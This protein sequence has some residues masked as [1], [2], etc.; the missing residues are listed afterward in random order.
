MPSGRKGKGAVTTSKH[1][2]KGVSTYSSSLVEHSSC[3]PNGIPSFMLPTILP[4]GMG[5][6]SNTKKLFCISNTCI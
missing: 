6:I 5:S 1:V 4:S 2:F 3:V